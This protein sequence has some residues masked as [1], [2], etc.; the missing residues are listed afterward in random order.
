[1]TGVTI[2]GLGPVKITVTGPVPFTFKSFRLHE[3]ERHVIDI[4]GLPELVGVTTPEP[5]PN[6]YVTK[7]RIGN[8]AGDPS[9]VSLV[10]D[11]TSAE[12]DVKEISG[13]GQQLLAVLVDKGG[14]VIDDIRVPGGMAVVLDAGH[15]GSDP[16]AQRGDIKEKELTLA[17]TDKLRKAL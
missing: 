12:V 15:G 16:G 7:V 10:L 13:Q 6:P 11:L 14:S 17:I 8:P 4:Q 9:T 1:D 2:G 3:P 5:Q